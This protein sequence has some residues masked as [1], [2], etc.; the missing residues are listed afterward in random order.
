MPALRSQDVDFRCYRYVAMRCNA[1]AKSDTKS[2]IKPDTKPD[3]KSDSES[4]PCA[5]S[6]VFA[7]S[8]S[9]RSQFNDGHNS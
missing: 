6:A 1:N 2:D 4:D 7:W 8:I 5:N 3:T 9:A